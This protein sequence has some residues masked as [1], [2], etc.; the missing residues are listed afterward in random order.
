MRY[1]R[2]SFVA[3]LENPYRGGCDCGLS[4]HYQSVTAQRFNYVCDRTTTE[5]LI[6]GKLAISEFGCFC[7]THPKGKISGLIP[8]AYQLILASASRFSVIKQFVAKRYRTT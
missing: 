6:F 5:I 3:G 7:G 2:V 1:E 8:M 4:R